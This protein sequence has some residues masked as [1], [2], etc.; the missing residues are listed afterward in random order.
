MGTDEKPKSQKQ[1]SDLNR[2]EDK[3]QTKDISK[4]KD[5][6]NILLNIIIVVLTIAVFCMSLMLI[7][8]TR[9]R[10]YEYGPETAETMIRQ[11]DRG[12]YNYLLSG[13]YLN[14]MLGVDTSGNDAYAVPYA[15]ADYYEA[16]FNYKGLLSAGDTAGASAYA[17]KMSEARESLGE[18]S[19]V[20]DDIDEFLKMP[21]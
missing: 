9:P 8:S 1:T 18:Y 15:A 16:A 3:G 19:Y 5:K 12:T 6:R 10:G 2:S 21:L 13:R 14:K 4:K 17:D 11:V 7:S 20:A